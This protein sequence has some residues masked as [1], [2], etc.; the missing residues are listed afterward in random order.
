MPGLRD[1]PERPG[2]VQAMVSYGV[3]DPITALML[4]MRYEYPGG[5]LPPAS[6]T[7][8]RVREAPYMQTIVALCDWIGDRVEITDT[9]VLRRAPAHE[10]YDVLGLRTWEIER[11]KRAYRDFVPAGVDL[12]QQQWIERIA[13][14]PWRNAG[15]CQALDRVWRGAVAC[16]AVE[17]HGKWVYRRLPQ[18]LDDEAW[19]ALGVRSCIGLLEDWSENPY[20]AGVVY[21]LLRSYVLRR[22]PVSWEEILDFVADWFESAAERR[23]RWGDEET[24]RRL[25]RRTLD[26]GFGAI[27]DTGLVAED[28]DGMALTDFGD[29]VVTAWLQYRLG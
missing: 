15:D 13:D 8:R 3:D 4:S 10:A 25:D 21:G 17:L 29:V 11:E 27:A 26:S 14:R 24:A 2:A 7:A 5:E 20:R 19:L 16:A 23:W 28:D 1:D 22:Q 6:R 12:D 9:G 18:E